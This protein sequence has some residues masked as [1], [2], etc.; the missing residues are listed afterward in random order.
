MEVGGDEI[1]AEALDHHGLIA[2]V[3][4]DLKIAQRIDKLLYAE[5]TGRHVTPGESVVAMII[6]GLGFTNRRLYLMPQFFANKPIEK[7][8]APGLK[9]EDITYDTLAA[10]LDE[11]SD[12]GE[13]KLYGEVAL[14]VALENQLLGTLNHLDTTSVSVKGDYNVP[15]EEGVVKLIHGHSKDHRPDLKQLL[16]SLVVT[17]DSRFPLWMEALDGNSSDKVNFHETLQRVKTFQAQMNHQSSTKW[18]ADSALYSKEK[19]AKTT[20]YLWLTR[21]P[22][23]LKE[24]QQLVMKAPDSIVWTD[25]GN[26][27]KTV[28][29]AS[30]YGDIDQRWLLVY[31]NQGYKREMATFE[32][33]LTKQEE[34]YQA[35]ANKLS[36][37]LFGCEQDAVKALEKFG[38]GKRHFHIM[39]DV[40]AVKKHA[41]KGR[42]K[43]G[44]EQIIK[45]YKINITVERDTATITQESYK[46]GRFI[47]ATNDLDLSNYSDGMML[48]DYK[49]QQDVEGG[50]RFLKDPWFMLNSV[51][52][53]KPQR[54][55][56]LMMVMTLCLM[57]YNVAEHRMRKNLATNKETLPNQKGKPIANP[58]LRWVFQM[59]E[60]IS[61]VS[62]QDRG[63]SE[64][65]RRIIVNINEIRKKII[66]LFGPT[67]CEIYGL[68]INEKID[69]PLRM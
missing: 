24:A 31:S 52:L 17:G 7:L 54:V 35:E 59:M 34:K 4:K 23:T 22:E 33:R 39:G 69:H 56:A 60:G 53:K 19:L 11:I 43:A 18:V 26:G 12:Y 3:C 2:A 61:I 51:F 32:K 41:G 46:K 9:P 57:V 1:K 62:L 37:Q 8:I 6:N 58:T 68:E 63:E 29:Y 5:D 42:P 48:N 50:F 66:Y 21:V 44:A 38:K 14:D 13:S 10:T 67:S 36:K 15:D 45:G 16:I 20:S 47:L 55:S 28:N 49:S 64:E 30:Q 27:Y 65:S 40:D 25:R